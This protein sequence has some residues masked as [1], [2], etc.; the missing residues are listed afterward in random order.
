MNAFV[1]HCNSHTREECLERGLF[2][3][4]SGGQYGPHSK[5]KK[6][7]LLF[8]AD[9]SAWTVTGIFTAKTDAGLNLDKIAWNGRFPWQIKVEAW[10]ELRTVHIDKVNEIIGLASGS[11]LN[12]LTKDQLAQ[13]VMSKEFG[14]CVPPHLFKV[15]NV[16]QTPSAGQQIPDRSKYAQQNSRSGGGSSA[17][18]MNGIKYTRI[19]ST[20]SST[21]EHPA[22]AMHRLKLVT[23][24]FDTMASELLMMNEL[25]NNKKPSSKKDSKEKIVLDETIIKALRSCQEDSWPL[26]SYSHVRRAIADVF[27]QWLMLAHASVGQR[28]KTG[29][30]GDTSTNG[31]WT[32]QQG[33]ANSSQGKVKE[34]VVLL[35]DVPGATSFVQQLLEASSGTSAMSLP[36][37]L[38]EL[39]ASKFVREIEYISSEVRKTQFSLMKIGGDSYM[40]SIED[41]ALGMKVSETEAKSP[42][43]EGDVPGR[44]IIKIEWHT[45]S[46]IAQGRPPQ[47][48]KI[49]K[50]HFDVLERSYKK[51]TSSDDPAVSHFL[52]RLFVLLCRHELLG[53]VKH[54]CQAT[55]P[56]IVQNV[57]TTQFGVAHECFA[58]P[59][60]NSLA[61]F[62]TFL[63]SDVCKFF[64]SLG[65]F[66]DF[67]PMEGSYLV[68]PPFVGPSLKQMFDHI[69]RVLQHSNNDKSALS[70][71]VVIRG[72]N[73]ILNHVK[74]SHFC[75]RIVALEDSP[76]YA[77]N[78]LHKDTVSASRKQPKNNPDDSNVVDCSGAWT[79]SFAYYII[80]LQ[81]DFGHDVWSPSDEKISLV[82]QSYAQV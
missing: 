45:K 4:P 39:V 73:P 11:K 8:L 46:S 1:F 75:R 71:L 65:S 53:D 64:G 43:G 51:Q 49:Y 2:G 21:D 22:T 50:T 24:W 48:Q 38:A 67:V 59:L 13:L 15:K 42:N 32:R 19:P 79:S 77:L 70:F 82:T 23:S 44:K 55:I 41:K 16:P 25:I 3:C 66:F 33:R 9:F 47:V 80:W 40:N 17:L 81:N 14:P 6:G 26:M 36:N 12:M 61:S 37:S 34:D 72:P 78:T 60:S 63:F 27:D 56:T 10:N 30:D 7:D 20:L 18:G 31:N 76:K 69:F 58:S 5:A 29:N 35:V 74:R 52:T 28:T 68:N 62:N 57:M 54:R